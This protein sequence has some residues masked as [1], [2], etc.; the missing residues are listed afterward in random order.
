MTFLINTIK[1]IKKYQQFISFEDTL[2][3]QSSLNIAQL[4]T[5]Y[6]MIRSSKKFNFNLRSYQTNRNI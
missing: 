3:N 2:N 4:E 1:D 6:E 5:I